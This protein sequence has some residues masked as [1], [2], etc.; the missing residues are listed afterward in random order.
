MVVSG[1]VYSVVGH[2][3]RTYGYANILIFLI[4]AIFFIGRKGEAMARKRMG[5]SFLRKKVAES[6][7]SCIF[8]NPFDR[9]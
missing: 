3:G 5:K 7:I 1:L 9:E 8:A 4:L 6:K 2:R